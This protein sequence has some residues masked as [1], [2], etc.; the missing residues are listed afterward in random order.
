MQINP[1]WTSRFELEEIPGTGHCHRIKKHTRGIFAS[2]HNIFISLVLNVEINLLKQRYLKELRSRNLA[3]LC[4]KSLSKHYTVNFI[5]S[6]KT[7]YISIRDSMASDM[8]KAEDGSGLSSTEL[9]ETLNKV[10]SCVSTQLASMK[11]EDLKVDMCSLDKT[12]ACWEQFAYSQIVAT[13]C[14]GGDT[15]IE[16]D[17]DLFKETTLAFKG[18]DCGRFAFLYLRDQ[19]F[20]DYSRNND[21]SS[22]YSEGYRD[23]L[24][25]WNY[26]LVQKPQHRDLVVYLSDRSQP[27]KLTPQH[28]GIYK[29][30]GQIIS[31]KGGRNVDIIFLHD[32][33]STA[34]TYG[35]RVVFFRKRF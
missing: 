9:Y 12:I 10:K 13:Y 20:L 4:I 31:K 35:S 5:D 21:A 15:I 1:T 32:I 27:G 25:Q 30:N 23:L 2:Y 17:E 33:D 19:Q 28:Y 22:F 8:N 26:Q 3:E 6:I 24:K 34:S 16:V 29:E 18:L 11:P 14:E 7:C